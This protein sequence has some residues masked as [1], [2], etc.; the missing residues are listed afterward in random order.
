MTRSPQTMS[1]KAFFVLQSPLTKWI[2]ERVSTQIDKALE[3]SDSFSSQTALAALH[4]HCERAS[5]LVRAFVLAATA[6]DAVSSVTKK[7]EVKTYGKVWKTEAVQPWETL[8]RKI[9]VCLL[10]S[11]RLKDVP[12]GPFPITVRNVEA[13]D[14]FSVYQWIAHDELLLSHKQEEITALEKACAGSKLVFDPSSPAGDNPSRWKQLQQAC[15]AMAIT[16]DERAEYLVDLEDDMQGALLLYMSNHNNGALLAAHRALLLAGYWLEQPS[17]I[18]LLQDCAD[19]LSGM[20]E[21]EMYRP[22][23]TAVRLEVWQKCIRP[24]FRALFFGFDEVHEISSDVFHDLFGQP[25]WIRTVGKTALLI[26]RLL[27]KLDTADVSSNRKAQIPDDGDRNGWPGTRQDLILQHVLEKSR[28][29]VGSAIDM[30]RAVVSGA[31]VS[32]DYASLAECLHGFYES[33]EHGALWNVGQG[34]SGDGNVQMVFLERAIVSHAR[35]FAPNAT[36]LELDEMETLAVLWSIDVRDVRTIFL[37]AMYEYGKDAMLEDFWSSPGSRNGVDLG[38]FVED[39]VALVCRRFHFILHERRSPSIRA[40]LSLL[41]AETLEWVADQ[42]DFSVSLLDEEE[43]MTSPRRGTRQVLD[44]PLAVS[45]IMVLRLLSMGSAL[46]AAI[47]QETSLK[48]HS[49]S[50]LSGTLKRELENKRT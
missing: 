28:P 4:D 47:P 36:Q 43:E 39:G 30:H 31:I 9:R 37:L 22:L 48:L 8:L 40:V 26:L 12:L 2:Q 27:A 23:A 17:R 3:E 10:V 18:P 41:D 25:D 46:G 29:V 49:L 13:P 11:L 34:A 38:R 15:L 50:V 6:R 44:V 14:I 16:D 33:F 19:A 45:H 20:D 21:S 7:A 32:N 35:D 24:V 5:D 42:A 1:H